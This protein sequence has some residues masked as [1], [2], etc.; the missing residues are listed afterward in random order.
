MQLDLLE[1]EIYEM[2][3]IKADTMK[4]I[5]YSVEWYYE[6]T[7]EK[8]P[9]ELVFNKVDQEIELENFIYNITDVFFDQA[10]QT[11]EDICGEL[12]LYEE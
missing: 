12:D 7:G 2:E 5:V 9:I 6:C 4:K 3:L 8:L 11:Y 1:N 10:L